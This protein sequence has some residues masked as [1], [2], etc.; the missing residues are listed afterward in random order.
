[1]ETPYEV[2]DVEQDAGDEAIKKAYL[3]K[4]REFPPERNAEAFQ[5]IRKAYELIETDKKRR[6]Y[7]LFHRE[8]PDVSVLLRRVLRPGRP[9]RPDAD[10]LIRALTEGLAEHLS[11]THADS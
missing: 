8:K 3:R 10:S 7:R 4:V 11:E 1:M 9:E 6:E 5:R 2:L